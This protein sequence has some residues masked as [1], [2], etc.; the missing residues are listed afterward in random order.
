MF[1]FFS[2]IQ[3]K[4]TLSYAFVTAGTVIVLAALLVGIA[5]YAE[6]LNN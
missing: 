4:L 2:R 5:L 6:N 1:K 3:W